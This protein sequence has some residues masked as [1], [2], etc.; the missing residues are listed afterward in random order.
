MSSGVLKAQKM[1]VLSWMPTGS[2]AVASCPAQLS[3]QPSENADVMAMS[4]TSLGV[5]P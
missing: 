3:A 4:L 1:S 2:R 5:S